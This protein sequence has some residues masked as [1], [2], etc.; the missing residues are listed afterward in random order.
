MFRWDSDGINKKAEGWLKH[1]QAWRRSGLAQVEYCAANGLHAKSFSNWKTK[2]HKHLPELPNQTRAKVLPPAPPNPFIEVKIDNES[3][4]YESL[5]QHQNQL[6]PKMAQAS[7]L[8]LHIGSQYRISI[9][10]GF[11]IST[12]QRLLSALPE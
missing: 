3:Q 12:L 1:M 9:E 7:G 6:Q 4:F 11:D 2:L 8:L 10:I 5:T